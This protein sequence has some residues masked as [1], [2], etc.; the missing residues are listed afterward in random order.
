MKFRPTHI[1]IEEISTHNFG[2]KHSRTFSTRQFQTMFNY[3]IILFVFFSVAALGDAA[4]RGAKRRL[5]DDE[6]SYAK[7]LSGIDEFTMKKIHQRYLLDRGVASAVERERDLQESSMSMSLSMS[8]SMSV[9][10]A[11]AD[12][13]AAVEGARTSAGVEGRNGKASKSGGAPPTSSKA[14]KASKAPSPSSSKS[15]KST[16]APSA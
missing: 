5:Q 9:A 7:L 10:F 4:I 3:K 14:S 12:S 15:S 13:S 2:I 16:K 8:L 1:F 6:S 11:E